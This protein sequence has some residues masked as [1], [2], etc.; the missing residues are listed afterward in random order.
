V[1]VNLITF[2]F[3]ACIGSFLNVCIYRIP[4]GMSLVTPGSRCPHCGTGIRFYDNL[5]IVGYLSLL[6]KCRTCR[7][8]IAWRY[9]FVELLT[10]LFALA[11]VLTFGLTTYALTVFVFVATLVVVTF[12]DLDHR[13][14][15]DAISLPG[16]PL[17]FV[18]AWANRAIRWDESALGILVGGGVLYAVAWGY[19]WITGRDGMGGGDI[20]LLAMIGAMIGWQG[21]VFTLFAASLTGTV[22][23]LL[24]ML[25]QR[26]GLRLAIPFGP[27]LSAGAVLYLFF[28]KAVVGWYSSL[29]G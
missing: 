11:C 2:V 22:V 5:P 26:D 7:S 8:A 16:I 21:V 29:L 4:A 14:I 12:I 1:V 3:G 9:P 20:K 28:G 13:I 23:G 15:P 24:A 19:R 27:F 17:F 10:G 25:R 6:G 18:A